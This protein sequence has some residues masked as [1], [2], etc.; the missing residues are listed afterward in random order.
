MAMNRVDVVDLVVDLVDVDLDVDLVDVDLVDIDLVDVDLVDVDLERAIDKKEITRLVVFVCVA[1]RAAS[2]LKNRFFS[3]LINVL[4]VP[5]YFI[6]VDLSIGSVLDVL[7]LKN[8]AE[9]T[10]QRLKRTSGARV[11]SF[12]FW[13]IS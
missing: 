7:V 3:Y 2:I 10:S 13:D 4:P 9:C 5:K 8:D 12:L 11:L 6:W 1:L